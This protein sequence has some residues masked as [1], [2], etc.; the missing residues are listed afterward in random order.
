MGGVQVDTGT[1]VQTRVTARLT[2]RE[3]S[4]GVEQVTPLRGRGWEREVVGVGVVGLSVPR[5][6]VRVGRRSESKVKSSTPK[7]TTT[8]DL[9]RG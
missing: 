1:E 5:A 8:E 6:S 3:K 9:R 2:V 4:P 7:V